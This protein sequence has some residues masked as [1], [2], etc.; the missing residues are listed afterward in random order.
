MSDQVTVEFTLNGESIT[1][2]A[3]PRRT[4]LDV[5]REEQTAKTD[6]EPPGESLDRSAMSERQ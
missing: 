3:A 5:L 4:V 2:T 1:H 6:R